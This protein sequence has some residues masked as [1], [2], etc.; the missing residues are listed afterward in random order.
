MSSF[1]WPFKTP[2][3]QALAD[4]LKV[5]EEQLC[6]APSNIDPRYVND[7]CYLFL[8]E[9]TLALLAAWEEAADYLESWHH[10][11]S[12]VLAMY[13]EWTMD[14]E[15]WQDQYTRVRTSKNP[16]Q[17][18]VIHNLC[19]MA[20]EHAY[21]NKQT[22]FWQGV[23]FKQDAYTDFILKAGAYEERVHA[24]VLNVFA[25]LLIPKGFKEGEA[26]CLDL[27]DVTPHTLK[28]MVRYMYQGKTISPRHTDEEICDLLAFTNKYNLIPLQVCISSVL[29]SMK[30]DAFKPIYEHAV[31][32]NC[33]Y[34]A[35]KIIHYCQNLSSK[36]FTFDK[37]GFEGAILEKK[38]KRWKKD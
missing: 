3:P 20:C 11:Y 34:M 24:C 2:L 31:R 33:M 27:E 4:R 35:R 26:M 9:E 36:E 23:P 7:F 15:A 16:Q 12:S 28:T 32:H 25:P 10:L 18:T 22:V 29:P 17:E 30:P 21:W 5:T 8:L 6:I 1:P 19:V 14:T 37:E 13:D 38:T